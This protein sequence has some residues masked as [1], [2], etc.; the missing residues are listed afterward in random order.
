M[1]LL[2]IEKWKEFTQ[3]DIAS[4]EVQLK[5]TILNAYKSPLYR[6]LWKTVGLTKE[7]LQKDIDLNQ[8]PLLTKNELFGNTRTKQNKICIDSVCHWFLGYDSEIHEWFPYG[9][10]DFLGMAP[11]LVRMGNT[12]GLK[13]GDI[14]LAIVDTPPRVSSFLPYLWSNSEISGSFGLEFIIGSMEWYDSLGMSWLNFIQKRPPTVIFGSTKNIKA[15]TEKINVMNDSVGEVLSNLRLGV[16]YGK[17]SESNSKNSEM[18]STLESFEVFSP[19]EHMTFCSECQMHDGVHLWLDKCIPEILLT[20]K[21]ETQLIRQASPGTGG[22]LILTN[23]NKALPLIRYQTGKKITVI[24]SDV[25]DC[26]CSHP[27]VLFS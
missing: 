26:G 6:R 4:Q 16:F 3:Q 22:E 5:T 20:D 17:Q 13:K 1:E 10:E 2:Q 9:E 27:R 11:M 15:L 23:F 12:V 14:V 21:N 25:C 18:V 7:T 8:L 24:S 19:T